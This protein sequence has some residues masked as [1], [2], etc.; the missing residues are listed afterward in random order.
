MKS[1]EDYVNLEPEFYKRVLDD[2][3]ELFVKTL[4]DVNVDEIDNVVIY[5]T[6]SS[7]NAS[8]GALPFMSKVLGLPVQI[9]EPSI[10]E[11][12]LM[13]VSKNTLSI[14]I[15]QGGHSYSVVEL[16][17]RLQKNGMTV[18]SL[19]SELDSPLA[20]AGDY[21][22]SMGM[23]IEEMPY[24]SAGYSVAILDL[25]LISLTVAQKSGRISD[26]QVTA[27][28]TEIRSIIDE[29]PNVISRATTWV[30][31][32]LPK[33][34]QAT[35]LSFVGYGAG[36][37]VAREGETKITEAVRISAWGKEL[38]EYMHG[39]YLGIHPDDAV[40]FIEPD[41]NLSGRTD[42]LKQFL[43]QHINNVYTIYADDSAQT[44]VNHDLVLGITGDEL[45][46]SLFMTVPIHLLA[47]RWSQDKGIDLQHSAYPDFDKITASKI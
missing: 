27:Y 45:L 38:E 31:Q 29:L 22:L 7:S 18:F 15:S 1:I 14:A 6:G 12:Y 3:E 9:Q 23:P 10:A 11:N 17:K 16:V 40:V 5:A 47:Y 37:G 2:Y 35:R 42:L 32:Q 36:Y 25:M 30:E 34:K 43:N 4:A 24:V 39:P 46:A 41:G 21:V 44:A 28:M 26:D 33:F 8:F 19:T 13:N 20:K